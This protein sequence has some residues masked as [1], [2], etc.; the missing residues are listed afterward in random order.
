M[1]TTRTLIASA[2]LLVATLASA[3]M[4]AALR[5]ANAAIAAGPLAWTATGNAAWLTL[6]AGSGATPSNIVL[7]A[8]PSGSALGAYWTE[9]TIQAGA[10]TET[11]PVRL[12]ILPEPGSLFLPVI[13]K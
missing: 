5:D 13:L 9:I 2:L 7:T 3:Q 10:T 6:S 1:K 12:E 11:V 4:P 8:N